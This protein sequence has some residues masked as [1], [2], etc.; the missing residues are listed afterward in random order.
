MQ[1]LPIS[2]RLEEHLRVEQISLNAA[3]MRHLFYN[4]CHLALIIYQPEQKVAKTTVVLFCFE[5]LRGCVTPVY[6]GP[7]S[8]FSYMFLNGNDRSRVNLCSLYAGLAAIT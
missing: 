6:T 2:S 5:T 4:F 7:A 1:V 8:C 3:S